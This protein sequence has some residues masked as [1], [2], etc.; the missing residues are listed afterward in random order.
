M[1]PLRLEEFDSGTYAVGFCTGSLALVDLV[2]RWNHKP[3]GYFYEDVARRLIRR[4]APGLRPLVEF[5]CEPDVF[6]AYGPDKD[7]LLE[8]AERM[9][10][11][12]RDPERIRRMFPPRWLPFL[13]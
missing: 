13:V 12:L 10:A 4:E 3:D 9:A 7:A 6:C 5:D 1:E 2:Y 8:L 11:V